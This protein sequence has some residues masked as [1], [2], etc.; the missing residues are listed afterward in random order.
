MSIF[1]LFVLA[2][3][4]ANAQAADATA[5][6]QPDPDAGKVVAT[7]D[8]RQITIGDFVGAYRNRLANV[9]PDKFPPMKTLGEARSFLDDLVTIQAI[10]TSAYSEGYDKRPQFLKDY[11]GFEENTLVQ[12][13]MSEETQNLKV[14]EEDARA[15]YDKGKFTR[16]IRYIMTNNLAD[17]QKA[18]A[19]ARKK[20]ADFSKLAAQLSIDKESANNGGLLAEPLQ[21]WPLEPF[22]S[23]FNL[24]LNTVSDPIQLPN[25]SGWGVFLVEKEQPAADVQ[26]WE[27]MKEY[28]LNQLKDIRT[29]QLRE[30]LSDQAFKDAKI[31][32]NQQNMDILYT[33]DTTT[34]D[35]F[36]DDIS[37]LIVSTVD[38]LPITFREWYGSAVFYLN[39]IIKLRKEQPEQ[40]RKA[41]DYQ[42]RV[43]EKGKALVSLCLKRKIQDLPDVAETLRNYRER[44][45]TFAYLKENIEDKIPEPTEAQVK[46]FYDAHKNEADYQL[47]ENID[48]TIVRGSKK[49]YVEETIARINKGEDKDAVRKDINKRAGIDV[50]NPDLYGKPDYQP[51][52]DC[53]PQN[54]VSTNTD[55]KD[56]YD[57]I[58]SLGEGK[59]SEVTERDG[60]FYAAR[61]DKLNPTRVKTLE[62][63]RSV[64]TSKVSDEIH[65]DPKTDK[66]CRDLLKKIHDRY[67]VKVFNDVLELARKKAAAS[68]L[69]E[70][71]SGEPETIQSQIP[72]K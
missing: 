60:S 6:V 2:M 70:L 22:I 40:L 27:D 20:G 44:E 13:L 49:E 8:S 56:Q 26:P 52:L 41:M 53:Y 72:G 17:A 38:G 4:G 61:L 50:D 3:V 45:I 14:T 28:Y 58:K 69:P 32:R 71:H 68:P 55:L 54:F 62:E 21:Y 59:W 57:A 5:S 36:K 23:L 48:A 24:P 10:L 46:A 30:Q 25:E 11:Q 1:L 39:N 19:E 33:G 51:V 12:A 67:P 29:N 43:V 18:A 42:L 63:A 35:W 66:M 16:I 37:N 64:I 7:V 31:E 47:V 65:M 9:T 15:F 34:D